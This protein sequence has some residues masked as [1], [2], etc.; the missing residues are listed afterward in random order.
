MSS[1]ESYSSS[2]D[3]IFASDS[4]LQT[5]SSSLNS[6]ISTIDDRSK[7]FEYISQNLNSYNY[8]VNKS[9]SIISS[10]DYITE[11]GTISKILNRSG[12][13]LTSIELS[14]SLPSESSLT[15]TLI[16]DVSGS[17]TSVEYS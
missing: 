13:V 17:I 8:M 12:S 10:I 15:K 9:G 16:R 6:Y 1:L 5:V 2:L 11:T 14:G 7:T 4:E 3:D